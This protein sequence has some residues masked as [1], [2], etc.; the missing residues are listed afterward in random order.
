ML[1]NNLFNRRQG[2]QG[3]LQDLV[4][5]IHAQVNLRHGDDVWERWFSTRGRGF[6]LFLPYRYILFR[7]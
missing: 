4:I 7:R 5:I 6:R 1:A 3:A 2:V